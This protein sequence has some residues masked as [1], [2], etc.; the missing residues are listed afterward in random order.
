MNSGLSLPIRPIDHWHESLNIRDGKLTH[1]RHTI[2]MII[3][4]SV[5]LGL[6]GFYAR[7][8]IHQF[9]LVILGVVTLISAATIIW[10]IPLFEQ[11]IVSG[12]LGLAFYAVV[13]I[14][15][16]FKKTSK[17]GKG[18][19][20][21][22]KEYSIFG[23][24]FLIPHFYVYLLTYINGTLTWEFYG[25]IAMVIMIPLFVMSF[26][27]FK[28][29]MDIK[30]WFRIQKFAYLAYLLIFIHLLV[31]GTGEHTYEYVLIFS[32]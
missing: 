19:R 9:Y 31:S 10:Y 17:I 18:L 28:K 30:K 5:V 4:L 11:M 3:L 29:K 1:E 8:Q 15:G 27:Y 25:V 13:M 6:V 26:D 22:R 12:Y 24:V 32:V 14:T 7:K 16:G 21:V 20:A 2:N 23:F